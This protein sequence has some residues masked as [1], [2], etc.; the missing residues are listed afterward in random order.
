VLFGTQPDVLQQC[1]KGGSYELGSMR[2]LSHATPLNH[3]RSAA[4]D[5]DCVFADLLRKV[6]DYQRAQH[7]HPSPALPLTFKMSQLLETDT[8]CPVCKNISRNLRPGG[9]PHKDLDHY[10]QNYGHENLNIH[11]RGP[12]ISVH[13]S[14]GWRLAELLPVKG[15][16]SFMGLAKPE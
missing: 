1:R 12:T 11:L 6:M 2:K 3:A 14:P 9:L 15:N 10:E 8:D 16:Y 4:Y 13:E 7:S 5:A